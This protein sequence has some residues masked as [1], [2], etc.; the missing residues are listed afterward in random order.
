MRLPYGMRALRHRNFRL[1]WTGML[2]SLIGTWMES[3]SQSWL[4]L[5]LTDDPVALGLRAAAQFTPV[6]ILGLFGGVIADMFPKRPALIVT[7]TAAGILAFVMFLL[8]WTNVVVPWEVY[9]IAAL[10]GTVNAF[11]MPIRQSFTVEMVGQEDVTSAVALNSSVFNGTRIVGPAVAGI[12]IATVGLSACFFLNAISYI[13]VVASLFMMDK[14]QLHQPPMLRLA[15]TARSV[16]D[17]LA[18]GVRYV[19]RT[20]ALAL[21]ICVLG[22]VSTVALNF[23]VT[24]PLLARDV[25]GGDAT[26]F[27]FLNSAAGVGSLIGALALAVTGQSPTFRRVLIGAGSIGVAMIGVGLS[28]VLPLS[29]VLLAIA[30]WGTITMGATTN[31]LIQLISPGN[32]RGRALSVYT[33]VFAGTTPLGGLVTGGLV[34]AVGTSVTFVA[35]GVASLLA[36]GAGWLLSANERALGVRITEAGALD[37]AAVAADR[38]VPASSSPS[39]RPAR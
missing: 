22:V 4:I 13:A 24:L 1:F 5:Q 31:M 29:L 8:V 23:Q 9:V 25:L 36:A 27:G 6:L 18:E 10:Y 33:T 14:S 15:R 2:I 26:T 20:R 21:A 3:V 16:I 38:S 28:T 12:L 35:A 17:Q 30:G 34:A 7:Q 39:E 32:L 19:A 37:A 11:D